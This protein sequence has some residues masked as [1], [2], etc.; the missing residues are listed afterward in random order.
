MSE[1]IKDQSL[2][3]ANVTPVLD[4]E[5]E[6]LDAPV[7]IEDAVMTS[8]ETELDQ[9]EELSPIEAVAEVALEPQD[10]EEENVESRPVVQ[11]KIV[12]PAVPPVVEVSSEPEVIAPITEEQLLKRIGEL[13]TQI[14]SY[15]F[16]VDSTD[17]ALEKAQDKHDRVLAVQ[18]EFVDWIDKRRAS[19]A[20]KLVERLRG[21]REKLNSDE[22]SIRA[23][24]AEKSEL[25]FGFAEKTRKWFMKR[26]MLN[27]TIS[28]VTIIILYLLH[29][30]LIHI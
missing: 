29:L 21:Y 15:I 4:S 23:F 25:E 2:Q 11:E 3:E 26:F 9:E 24:A 30:S 8:V 10:V 28:W 18:E 16:E 7:A 22:A 1:E 19:Y 14:D 20:W 12:A 5:M 13:R 17:D 6:S 27:F